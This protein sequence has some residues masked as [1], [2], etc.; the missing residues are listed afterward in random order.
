M[1]MQQMAGFPQDNVLVFY[2]FNGDMKRDELLSQ[3]EGMRAVGIDGFFVH[4]RAGLELEYMGKEWLDRFRFCVETAGRLGLTVYI[5][6]EN[7]WPS[8]FCGGAVPALGEEYQCKFILFSKGVPENVPQSRIIA[9][10]RAEGRGYSR[11]AAC[12]AGAGDLVAY[13][14]LEKDYVDLLYKD[15]IVKF[16]E[17]THERYKQHF[18]K[19]FGGVIKG[20]FTDE[21]QMRQN[22]LAWSFDLPEWYKNRYGGDILDELWKLYGGDTPTEFSDR[23]FTVLSSMFNENFSKRLGDWCADNNLEFTGHYAS[24]DGISSQIKAT[25]GVVSN[26]RYQQMPGIDHLGLRLASP[27]LM[28]QVSSA[29]EMLEKKRIISE[30]F[31]CAG[32]DVSF[33]ELLWIWNWHALFGINVPCLHLTAYSI[34]GRRKR[35]YPAFYSYQEP[36]WQEFKYISERIKNINGFVSRS[37]RDPEVLVLS[38]VDGCR[39]LMLSDDMRGE[40]ERASNQYRSLLQNLLDNQMDFDIGDP[41]ILLESASFEDGCIRIGKFAYKTLIIPQMPSIG[42]AVLDKVREFAKGGG[43]LLVANRPPEMID[44]RPAGDVLGGLDYFTVNNRCDLWTKAFKRMGTRRA[45]QIKNP[46]E[47]GYPK[48]VALRC[49]KDGESLNV[50][51]FNAGRSARYKGLDFSV[52]FEADIYEVNPEDGSFARL[53]AAYAGGRTHA[54]VDLGAAASLLLRAEPKSGDAAADKPEMCCRYAIR[55]ISVRR[56]E[57]NV[58]TLDYASYSLCGEFSKVMPTVHLVD[59]IYKNDYKNKTLTLKYTFNYSGGEVES[60]AFE[61]DNATAL[62]INGAE[63]SLCSTGWYI[64]KCIGTYDIKE[65]VVPGENTILISYRMTHKKCGIDCDEIFETQRNIF[66]YPV[67]PESIYILGDFNVDYEGEI[68]NAVT[69]YSCDGGEFVICPSK[70]LEAGEITAQG[71]WF[72]RGNIAYGFTAEKPESGSVML[73]L[74]R[75]S[76]TL[77][78]VNINGRHCGAIMAEPFELDITRFMRAGGN[79]IE[80]IAHGHNRNVLGPHH[81]VKGKV[82]FVGTSTFKG[83]R[84]Y[85]DFVS[86]ELKDPSTWTDSYSFVPFGLGGISIEI[87]K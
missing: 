76:C 69:H 68:E 80:I 33:N 49:C 13:F 55:D 70:A 15:T 22:K 26:Y 46:I 54:L 63:I 77:C 53:E 21:P 7:G 84:G 58:I 27:V 3:L 35:D 40:I 82:C 86:P 39:S 18:S 29:A 79:E 72:Y 20:I 28:R 44:G 85:E 31:G 4:A 37:C 10:Y 9:V 6:D 36:W 47:Q 5:Y 71:N 43:R 60:V 67:E 34:K 2:S 17:F 65:H 24:E 61:Y 50:F 51:A 14:E 11:I 81:H 78:T 74:D 45:A 64:D 41:E 23:Y 8:G 42:S 66:F 56:K 30:V 48:D 32:W 57:R 87:R 62:S 73:T 75:M 52:P 16:I 59:E 12:D 19:Y 38:V 25:G 1:A 83:K